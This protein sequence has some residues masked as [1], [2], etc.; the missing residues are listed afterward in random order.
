MREDVKIRR[1]RLIE[2]ATDILSKGRVF[3]ISRVRSFAEKNELDTLDLIDKIM[4]RCKRKEVRGKNF[5]KFKKSAELL[6]IESKEGR[7]VYLKH[8]AKQR[9]FK[10]HSKYQG[11]LV[12]Q[13]G[14]KSLFEREK[15]VKGTRFASVV[16]SL[17]EMGM[18]TKRAVREAEKII[19]LPTK[20]TKK[21][22][23][24]IRKKLRRK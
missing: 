4:K 2:F 10:S 23:L 9:G 14:F 24:R 6:R 21:K 20:E 11:Y 7:T 18:P 19:K 1:D 22:A 13:K 12:K 17:E 15:F 5:E 16:S 8:L 3:S